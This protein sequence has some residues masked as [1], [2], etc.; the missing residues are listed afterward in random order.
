MKR[1]IYTQGFIISVA[2]AASGA[3]VVN[4]QDFQGIAEEAIRIEAA[5]ASG[6]KNVFVL[7]HT[8]GVKMRLAGAG[9]SGFKCRSFGTAGAAYA[10]DMKPELDGSYT[11]VNGDCGYEITRGNTTEYF[12]VTDYERHEL[13]MKSLTATG[14][15]DC[16]RVSFRFEGQGGEIAYYSPSGRR[17]VLS[18]DIAL[19]YDTQSFDDEAFGF[20]PSVSNTYLSALDADLFLNASLC[21]TRYTLRGD[22]FLRA[23]GREQS[24]ESASVSPF[25]VD[26]RT[27]ATQQLREVDNEQKVEVGGLG[28]SAPCEIKFEACVSDAAIFHQW[29]ISHSPSFDIVDDTYTE[30]DF[31]YTFREQGTFYVRFVADNA[32][33]TCRYEGETYTVNIG[34]SSLVIPNA[35]S[36]EASPGVNDLWKVSYKSIVSFEC[37]IFNRWGQELFHTTNPADGWDGRYN[38][39]YVPAGVYFY[40]IKARGADGKNYDRAGDINIVK[41]NSGMYT[42]EVQQ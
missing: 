22:R 3:N 33:G 29:E 30:L 19:E 8:A 34:E 32:T 4:A 36:P 35:F 17:F 18:R 10:T 41:Y 27:R 15:E 21:D 40:V 12:W 14:N 16:Q 11:L 24:V 37:R 6:L 39:K 26:A 31:S 13:D 20:K 7:P 5:S 25:A 9:E 28:G 2:V 38:G 42:P 1:G 23:W